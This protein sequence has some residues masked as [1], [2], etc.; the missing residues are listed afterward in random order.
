M[1]L[2]VSMVNSITGVGLDPHLIGDQAVAGALTPNNDTLHDVDGEVRGERGDVIDMT[3]AAEVDG[4]SQSSLDAAVMASPAR[5]RPYPPATTFLANKDGYRYG[6]LTQQWRHEL[7]K[8][9]QKHVERLWVRA[10]GSCAQ[11]AFA[12]GRADG[13]K[14]DISVDQARSP[15]VVNEFRTGAIR[16]MVE[17]LSA[18]EWDALVPEPLR[19]EVWS[20]RTTCANCESLAACVCTRSSLAERDYFLTLCDRPHSA[21]EP[22]FF[23]FAAAVTKIGVLLLYDDQRAGFPSR[24]VWSFGVEEYAQSMVIFGLFPKQVQ[25]KDND[26]DE[27]VRIGHYETVGVRR[28]GGP[29]TQGQSGMGSDS[30]GAKHQ[31]LFSRGHPLLSVLLRQAAAHS[32]TRTMESERIIYY[33]YLARGIALG[34]APRP[35]P[36]Q[37]HRHL[38][39]LR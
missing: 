39:Q 7:L 34:S 32:G 10:D 25:G 11:G 30:E 4:S 5:Q 21:I 6:A 37:R 22:F 36:Y 3:D 31:T 17:R 9:K 15:S 27:F 29:N 12:L 35:H 26:C 33:E 2:L 1:D 23:H 38:L 24:Q 18:A 20:D 13:G 14:G 8:H 16:R 19:D 28:A